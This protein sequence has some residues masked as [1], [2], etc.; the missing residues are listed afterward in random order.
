[1]IPISHLVI[2]FIILLAA[3]VGL[4]V[5]LFKFDY[6]KFIRSELFVKI[7]FWIPIFI[8]LVGVL[9]ANN[10]IR[11]SVLIVLLGASLAEVV[12]VI[13]IKRR[14]LFAIY[15]VLFAASSAC[16]IF[17]EMARP[18][19]FVNILITLGFANVL[20]DVAAFFA[21]NYLGRHKLPKIFNP[22]KS[23]EG[24]GGEL[25]GA[26]AGVLLVNQFV[27][28]VLSLWLFLPIGLGS[29]IGDLANSYVKRQAGIK[30]WSRAI[31]GHGGFTDR[32]SSLA[33]SAALTYIF[34]LIT[35]LY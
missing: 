11:L 19:E 28:P 1:M 35:G 20:A 2:T 34:I 9:Y 5:P 21:G 32:L 25:V 16:L 12:R 18:G 31:P 26:L 3:G 10:P 30:D 13:R 8:I 7:L 33:G 15:Y 14:P 24:V 29:I 23:W 17:I 22:R 6:K 27:Q 4:T